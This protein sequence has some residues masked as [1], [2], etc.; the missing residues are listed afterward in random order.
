MI[1][2]GFLQVLITGIMG[3]VWSK[4]SDLEK[5]DTKV[6]SRLSVIET[7]LGA[8]EK[9]LDRIDQTAERLSIVLHG[10]ELALASRGVRR[11]A[12]P[13]SEQQG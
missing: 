6:E 4:I 11:V 10:L 12:T 3:I 5:A 8:Q 2:L 13:P 7:K 9:T 1:V